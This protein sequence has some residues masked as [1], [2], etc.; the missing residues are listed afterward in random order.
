M[1]ESINITYYSIFTI[2]CYVFLLLFAA[3]NINDAA[4]E[5][6]TKFKIKIKTVLTVNPKVKNL[7]VLLKKRIYLPILIVFKFIHQY[8]TMFSE[9]FYTFDKFITNAF[10]VILGESIDYTSL[11]LRKLY[12]ENVQALIIYGSAAIVVF[13]FILSIF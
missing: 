11:A 6:F 8:L 2:I 13:Y 3:V 5:Y 10:G 12:G 1:I 9:Y 7:L 4:E